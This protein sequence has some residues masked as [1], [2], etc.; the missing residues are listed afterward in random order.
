MSVVWFIVG[1][2]VAIECLAGLLSFR[3]LLRHPGLRARAP[4]QIVLPTLLLG[5]VLWLAGPGYVVPL[6]AAF[7]FVVVWQAVIFTI[8][9]FVIARGR[10]SAE[11]IDTDTDA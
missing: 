10:Y 1:I 7:A 11:S 3:D 8:G 5:V 4:E 2:P 6:A 9:R